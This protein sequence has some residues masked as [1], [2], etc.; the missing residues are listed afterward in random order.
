[1]YLESLSTTVSEYKVKRYSVLNTALE[2][3][4]PPCY[5]CRYKSRTVP[6]AATLSTQHDYL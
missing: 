3:K 4:S 1:M 6:K 2:K 5:T